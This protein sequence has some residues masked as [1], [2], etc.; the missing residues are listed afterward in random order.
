M[1]LFSN[2]L[3]ILCAL[4]FLYQPDLLRADE[5]GTTTDTAAPSRS[6]IL[7]GSIKRVPDD[8]YNIFTFPVEHP[9]ESRMAAL[10]VVALVILDKPLT[11]FY[12]NHIEEPLSGFRLPDSPIHSSA[13]GSF[14]N[15]ADGWLLLGVGGTYLGGLASGNEKAQI[16]GL[17]SAKALAYS[18]VISQLL[19]KSITGRQ[20]P[21]PSGSNDTA[22]GVYTDD[23]YRF[24]RFHAPSGNAEQYATAMPSFHFTAYFAVAKVYQRAY[25]NYWVPYSLAAVGLASNIRGHRHWVSD[26]VAGALVGTAI[27][28]AVSDAEATDET[29]IKV[30]PYLDEHGAG[31]QIYARY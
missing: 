25:D 22:D 14:T 15:G 28:M 16:T 31:L 10:G 13:A 23:P 1:T 30:A 12:R 21:L 5:A 4:C 6:Q 19:L 26:M 18:Y 17:Q 9:E 7:A 24:G 11:K 20:R 8:L 29:D 3:W 27:G 2:K